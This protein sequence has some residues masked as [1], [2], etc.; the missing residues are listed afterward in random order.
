MPIKALG[1]EKGQGNRFGGNPQ[2]RKLE[3]DD[4]SK[5]GARKK[6]KHDLKVSQ[7][8]ED[9]RDNQEAIRRQGDDSSSFGCLGG[10][11]L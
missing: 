7:V 2:K 1:K 9:Q 10:S 6:T 8:I 11:D 4:G 3:G 5:Q